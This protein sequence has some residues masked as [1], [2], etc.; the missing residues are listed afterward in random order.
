M[1]DKEPEGSDK[2][3]VEYVSEARGMAEYILR[4]VHR[5]PGDTVDAAMYRAERD[6]LVASLKDA[7]TTLRWIEMNEAKIRAAIVRAE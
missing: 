3:S 6:Y 7:G 1:S 5:G 2:M 4:K